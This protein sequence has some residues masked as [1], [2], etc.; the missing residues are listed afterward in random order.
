MKFHLGVTNNSWYDYLSRIHPEDINFWQPGGNTPFKVLAP[1][2]PFLFKL[3]APRNVI[4]GV[5]FFSSHTTFPIRTA[6]DIF[7]TRNG[8]PDFESFL[9]VIQGYRN[10]RDQNPV[11][12]CIVLTDPI[13]FNEV[14]WIDVSSIWSKSIVQGKSYSTNESAGKELWQRIYGL[15]EKY[16]A[17]RADEPVKDAL[18]ISE[19]ESPLYGMG[20]LRKVRLGQG[21]FRVLVTDAYLRRCSISGEKTLPVLEAAHIKSYS[22]SGPHAIKNGLLLRADVHKLFDNG[23]ITVTTDLK[24]EVSSKIKEEFENGREYYQY[25][26]KDLLVLPQ[27]FS[28]RPDSKY[29]NWHNTNIFRG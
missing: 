7:S 17:N 15:I 4:G 20:I 23:Y 9:R 1:G 10:D 19:P 18:I 25:H 12:G 3:K 8:M 5:G 27:Q 21:P 24:V 14:D 29:L 16:M 26:G 28:D 6:W 11:I 22:S 2:E 13:F